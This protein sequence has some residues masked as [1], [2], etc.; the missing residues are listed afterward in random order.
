MR[1]K[2]IEGAISMVFYTDDPHGDVT[3]IVEFCRQM[4]L[5]PSD[6]LV[7]LGDVGANYYL[8]ERDKCVKE[9]LNSCG[10]T[11]LCIHGNHECRPARISSY[12]LHDWNGGQVYV[13]PE[14]PRVLFAMDGEVYTLESRDH[15]VIGGAYSVDK[16]YRLMRGFRWWPDEQPDK[17]TKVKVE[18]RL[19]DR[20]WQVPIVLSH[21]CPFKYEPTEAFLPGIDQSS[22]D[23]STERWLDTIDNRL[24]YDA[25]YCG[26]WHINKR[27]E[28]MHFLFH[29]FE[30][31]PEL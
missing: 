7:I 20:N 13:Q 31:T 5:Q 19:A 25:W 10:P 17:A 30:A 8:N 29:E 16:Y 9:Q 14:Y 27:I 12:V 3:E 15:L 1:L 21:T 6:T 4:R 2:Q 11:I 26:H 28:K 22:V 18:Q 23:D 24:T